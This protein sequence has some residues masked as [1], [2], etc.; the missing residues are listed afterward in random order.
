MVDLIPEG[1]VPLT[2][3]F[4][5][6]RSW[7]WNGHSPVTELQLGRILRDLPSTRASLHRAKLDEVTDL[8]FAEMVLAFTRGQLSSL[9]RHPMQPETITVPVSAWQEAFFPERMFLANVIRIGHGDYFDAMAGSTPFVR[10]P[11][12]SQFLENAR[13]AMSSN[14]RD[15]PP[16]IAL[17]T[18][19]IGLVN[20][21]ALT[22]DAA[23][24]FTRTWGL[25]PLSRKPDVEQFDPLAKSAWTLAM[26]LAWIVWR[27]L[28]EVR[29]AWDEYRHECWEWRGVNRRLPIDGGKDW[30]E[31][32]GE[33]LQ[34]LSPMTIGT[35]GL[36][37][38]LDEDDREPAKL[39]SVKSAREDL[40]QKL[41]DGDLIATG[42]DSTENVTS[43][44]SNEW[45]YLEPAARLDGPEYIVFSH[46]GMKQPT[47]K[48]LSSERRS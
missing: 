29:D 40:W 16:V 38:A 10:Q 1:C 18:V 8:E 17:R 23:E 21:G 36:L 26:T 41:G 27:Q 5:Q 13:Y 48:S 31:V 28:M 19:L 4:D 44:P 47:R 34:P 9:A 15:L 32:H 7:L 25:K 11:E 20:D 3:A 12:L 46:I 37:E 24:A 14:H 2:E 45:G 39:I 42:L 35:L 33:E 30:Y 6:Y 22:S 43:I